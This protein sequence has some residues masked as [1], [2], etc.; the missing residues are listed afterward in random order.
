MREGARVFVVDDEPA[1]RETLAAILYNE[2]YAAIPFDGGA[3]AL[4]SAAEESPDLLITEVI[5][6]D[7]NGVDLAIHFENLYPKCKILL[8]SGAPAAWDLLASARLR[9]H[10]FELL[11]KPLQPVKLLEK[12]AGTLGEGAAGSSDRAAG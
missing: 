12:V 4:S 6:P 8:V 9:G 11:A 5:M 3:M 10:D 2:G 7:M 1:I